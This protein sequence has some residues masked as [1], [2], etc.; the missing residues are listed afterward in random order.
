MAT[1]ALDANGIW[2]YGEDDSE[3][4]FS[5]MLNKLASSTSSTVTR[6]ENFT[7]MT[8]TL[9]V[10]NGGTGATT[11][12]AAQAALGVAV[13]QVVSAKYGTQVSNAS[14]AYQPTGL[15]ATI[16]P[17]SASNKILVLITQNGCLRPVGNAASRIILAIERNGS[18][19]ESSRFGVGTST[20]HYGTIPMSYL[21]SPATTSA[22]TY[23][24]MFFNEGGG[25]V[26]VQQSSYSSTITLIEVKG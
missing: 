25:T 15:Q 8:G 4:T 22:L 23:R 5:G 9:P 11:V 20:D 1:G 18:G 3:P 13:V 16:T 12:A 6:L 24:T 14:G 17:T 2:Q 10:A 26:Y 21:D 19:L 7:G